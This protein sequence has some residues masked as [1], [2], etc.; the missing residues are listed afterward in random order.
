MHRYNH[1]HIIKLVTFSRWGWGWGGDSCPCLFDFKILFAII[2]IIIISDEIFQLFHASSSFSSFQENTK[3]ESIFL[4]R[5][6]YA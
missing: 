6:M 1:S 2:I 3:C 5:Y 4:R